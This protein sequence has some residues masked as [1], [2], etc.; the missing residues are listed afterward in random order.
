MPL[1][2]TNYILFIFLNI[3]VGKFNSTEVL[4]K[5]NKNTSFKES[6]KKFFNRPIKEIIKE[7]KI[8]TGLII[9]MPFLIY[10]LKFKNIKNI[11]NPNKKDDYIKLIENIQNERKNTTDKKKLHELYIKEMEVAKSLLELENELLDDNNYIDKSIKP[12]LKIDSCE[13]QEIK[14]NKLANDYIFNKIKSKL[15]EAE[16]MDFID[17]NNIYEHTSQFLIKD[18]NSSNIQIDF[19]F[20]ENVYFSLLKKDHIIKDILCEFTVYLGDNV[21]EIKKS[22]FKEDYKLH[23]LTLYQNGLR[24]GVPNNCVL[25]SLEGGLVYNLYKILKT[26]NK[27]LLKNYYGALWDFNSFLTEFENMKSKLSEDEIHLIEETFNS[28]DID[29]FNTNIETLNNNIFPQHLKFEP[30][31]SNMINNIENK[32]IFYLIKTNIDKLNNI[33]RNQYKKNNCGLTSININNFFKIYNKNSVI[34]HPKIMN[35]NCLDKENIKE[36]NKIQF[37][38]ECLNLIPVNNISINNSGHVNFVIY[39]KKEEISKVKEFMEN[40]Y[41]WI[42]KTYPNFVKIKFIE[43]IY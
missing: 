18:K 3:N 34:G 23:E 13:I 33:L 8:I 19:N 31:R 17:T 29:L 40:W 32:D 22:L 27:D 2:K 7:N 36:F 4:E 21:Y 35:L 16:F 15:T 38:N 42:N 11:K 26:K 43:N 10:F 39:E 14:S 9:T 28:E 5:N 6:V 37:N 20:N 24:N 41:N 30:D 25:L 1:K 12:V